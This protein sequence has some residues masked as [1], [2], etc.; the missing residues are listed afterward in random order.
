M[1][2]FIYELGE[3]VYGIGILY[4]I[5]AANCMFKKWYCPIRADRK[6]DTSYSRTGLKFETIYGNKKKY[7]YSNGE[8]AD[9]YIWE[10]RTSTY[11]KC[12]KCGRQ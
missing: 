4:C 5:F 1:S 8:Y 12:D 10:E 11:G 3:F 2:A 9:F 6:G 7:Q